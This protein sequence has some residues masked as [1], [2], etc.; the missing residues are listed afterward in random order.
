M[1]YDWRD[2]NQVDLLI[3]GEEFYP[4]VFESIRNAKQEVLLETFIIFEDKVGME[5]QQALIAA[6]RN[7]ASVEITV[8]GYGTADLSTEYVA[9]LTAAGVRVHMFDPGKRLLGMRTN[10]FRRLHRLSLIHI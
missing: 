8:D 2:G 1:K 3:N 9:A 6:A 10:L 4:A 7:G 5:L